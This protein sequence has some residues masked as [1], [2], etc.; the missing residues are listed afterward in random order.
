M[1]VVKIEL[2]SARTG[3]VTEIGRTYITN[4][5][6]GT[7]DRR[8]YDVWICRRGRYAPPGDYK[9]AATRTASIT[10]FPSKAYNVWRLIA[11]ALKAAFPEEA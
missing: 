5:G 3:R 1:I 2:W 11:R 8:N 4:D 7:D 10:K 9:S 6:T